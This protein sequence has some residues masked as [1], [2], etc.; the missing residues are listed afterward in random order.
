MTEI[1]ADE[2]YVFVCRVGPTYCVVCVC[3]C[4]VYVCSLRQTHILDRVCK[5]SNIITSLSECHM[6]GIL[7]ADRARR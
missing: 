7:T 4:D 5:S 1:S 2:Y 3:C 6:I